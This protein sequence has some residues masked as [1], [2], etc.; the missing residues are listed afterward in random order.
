MSNDFKGIIIATLIACLIWEL[1]ERQTMK[2]I[3]KKKRI[4]QQKQREK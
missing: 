2:K 3:K 1:D 4:E